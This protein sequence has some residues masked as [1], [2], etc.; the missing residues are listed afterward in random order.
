MARTSVWKQELAISSLECFDVSGMARSLDDI[1]RVVGII[2]LIKHIN[3][4][5]KKPEQ[6]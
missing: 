1:G 5:E 6:L 4:N 3:K 2:N